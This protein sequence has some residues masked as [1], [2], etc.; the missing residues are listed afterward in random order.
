MPRLEVR[1]VGTREVWYGRRRRRCYLVPA[2]AVYLD[3]RE[4][5]PWMGYREACRLAREWR[6]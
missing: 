4:C 5:Q 3:G 1:R 6:P 2:W